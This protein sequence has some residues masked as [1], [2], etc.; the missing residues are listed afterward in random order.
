MNNFACAF[1]GKKDLLSEKFDVSRKLL[2]CLSDAGLLTE[3]QYEELEAM[4]TNNKTNYARVPALIKILRKLDDSDGSKFREF[5]RVL[6][7]V[8]QSHIIEIIR[9][10]EVQS[11]EIPLVTPVCETCSRCSDK[12]LDVVQVPG[13]DELISELEEIIEP[14]YGLVDE[15][16]VKKVITERQCAEVKGLREIDKVHQRVRYLLELLEQKLRKT[17]DKRRLDSLKNDDFYVSLNITN[18]THVV[19]YIKENGRISSSFGGV[20]PLSEQQR[21]NLHPRYTLIMSDLNSM[22]AVLHDRL[23]SEAILCSRQSEDILCEKSVLAGNERLLLI[24]KRKSVAHVEHFIKCLLESGFK[25]IAKELIAPGVSACIHTKISSTT[26]SDN[27]K[28]QNE[29]LVTK[30][31]NLILRTGAILLGKY[32]QVQKSCASLKDIGCEVT[33]TDEEH[34]VVWY[35][36]CQS[37]QSLEMLRELYESQELAKILH[38]MFNSLCPSNEE[39]SL[40]VDWSTDSFEMCKTYWRETKGLP[41][42]SYDAFDYGEEGSRGHDFSVILSTSPI[43]CNVCLQSFNIV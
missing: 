23:K 11:V 26:V 31:I 33:H 4:I 21:L 30:L 8:G 7:E 12:H 19:N 27:D 32:P 22:D 24:M 38:D 17:S 14:D 2:N 39:L 42:A 28:Q 41:F 37:L 3:E 43:F 10:D 16:C 13:K 29:S 40:N 15:L 1:D 35:I 5:C 9:R 36:R 34:S 6:A 20:R 18:Q 25:T